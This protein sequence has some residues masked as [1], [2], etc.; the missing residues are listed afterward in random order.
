MWQIFGADMVVV[1]VVVV[2]VVGHSHSGVF[3]VRFP[4]HQVRPTPSLK[5]PPFSVSDALSWMPWPRRKSTFIAVWE[6]L[7]YLIY[8][9]Q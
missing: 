9:H 4:C 2:V 6:P 7:S 3:L 1:V 5:I 8:G